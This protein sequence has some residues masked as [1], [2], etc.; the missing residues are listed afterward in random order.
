VVKYRNE[1]GGTWG[2]RGKRPDWLRAALAS[3]KTLADFEVK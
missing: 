3:G 2:G 1:T